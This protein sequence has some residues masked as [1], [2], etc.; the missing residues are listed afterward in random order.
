[1]VIITI[2][3]WSLYRL[4]DAFDILITLTYVDIKLHR[5]SF[6]QNNSSN[7]VVLQRWMISLS[8]Q[9]WKSIFTIYSN[10]IENHYGKH[11]GEMENSWALQNLIMR[12]PFTSNHKMNKIFFVKTSVYLLS[13]SNYEY[14]DEYQCLCGTCSKQTCSSGYLQTVTVQCLVR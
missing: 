11:I 13:T 10:S 12:W 1:M 3:K 2:G 8:K 4:L 9:S 14:S 6:S 5:S 7:P